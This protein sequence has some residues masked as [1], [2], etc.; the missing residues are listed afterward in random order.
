MKRKAVLAG[1]FLALLLQQ[2]PL[3][4]ERLRGSEGSEADRQGKIYTVDEIS[5]D[6][7]RFANRRVTIVGFLFTEDRLA[8]DTSFDPKTKTC[9]SGV[10]PII[11]SGMSRELFRKFG[12]VLALEMSA[13]GLLQGRRV[14]IRGTF[15]NTTNPEFE[16]DLLERREAP[17]DGLKVGEGGLI[18]PSN[19]YLPNEY[20]FGP[21]VDPA[22][23]EVHQQQCESP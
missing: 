22:I 13:R 2:G 20:S 17:S 8:S 18:V 11:I 7:A 21:L 3:S 5:S 12:R 4:A 10:K 9:V 6:P 15:R 19:E 14:T 23:I 1:I 16:A